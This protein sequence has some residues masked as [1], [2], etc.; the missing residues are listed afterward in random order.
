MLRFYDRVQHA[1]ERVMHE[2][3]PREASI[4]LLY[5]YDACPQ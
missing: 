2:N 5:V 1:G 4:E 3:S